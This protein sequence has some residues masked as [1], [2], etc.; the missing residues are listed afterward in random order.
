MGLFFQAPRSSAVLRVN[1]VYQAL[2]AY[3]VPVWEALASRPDI[4]LTVHHARSSDLPSTQ[5]EGFKTVQ[6]DVET[7]VR[8]RCV[9]Y[10]SLLN[11]ASRSDSDVLIAPWNLRSVLLAPAMLKA[12]LSGVGTVLWGH[13]YSKREKRSKAWLRD[14]LGQLADSLVFYDARTADIFQARNPAFRGAFVA[15]NTLDLDAIEAARSSGLA[16]S[17][18]PRLQQLLG[19][20][21][22]SKVGGGPTALHVSRLWED[23]GVD[24]ILEAT[25][26]VPGM[27]TIVVGDGPLLTGLRARATSLGIADRVHFVGA[28]YREEDLAPLFALADLFIY[29]KNVGLSL[30]HALAYGVPVLTGDDLASHNPEVCAL[31]D[32]VNGAF[33]RHGD[34]AALAE[35]VEALFGA[36]DTLAEMALA[37]RE[38]VHRDF[39]M[40]RMVDGL[41]QAIRYAAS[42]RRG[43]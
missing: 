29:P 17:A 34:A 22:R 28:M 32:G 33:F 11:L 24:T 20:R 37:A 42:Q 41:E 15:P 16:T 31:K 21:S 19:D 7:S 9:V 4:D 36:P 39:P 26:L 14:S 13:G 5:P 12:R 23:N 8:K 40:K 25:A 38:G 35:K 27:N 1:L 30:I 18:A 2:P 10:P 43:R 6:L 3:R